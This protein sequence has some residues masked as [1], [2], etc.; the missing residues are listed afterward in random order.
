MEGFIRVRMSLADSHYGGGVVAGARVLQLVGDALT[1]A[2]I[3]HDGDEG[4]ERTMNV[5]L[6]A[7][8]YAGDYLEVRARLLSIGRSSRPFE[9]TVH[10]CIRLLSPDGSAA[11]VLSEPVLVM[12]ASGVAVVPVNKQRS[13]AS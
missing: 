8:V 4:L 2:L 13:V 10:K 3:R 11:E 5:E 6:L 9:C 1:E 7:P 12:K